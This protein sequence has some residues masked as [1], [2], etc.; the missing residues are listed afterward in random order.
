MILICWD[1]GAKTPIHD[2]DGQHCWVLQVS[3]SIV[4]KRFE[5]KDAGFSLIDEAELIAGKISYMNYKMGYNT[6][7]NNSESRE[8][9][10]HI[11]ANPIN[12]CNVYNEKKSK[13]E[14]KEMAY[15]TV[16]K[17]HLSTV[18]KK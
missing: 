9:T 8:M 2:H 17:L 13:F 10:L 4:E 15:D 7:E 11:Y 14:I 12:Q 5:K 18:D 1:E 16:H 6:L 3:G